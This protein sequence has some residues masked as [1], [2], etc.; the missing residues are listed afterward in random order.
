MKVGCVKYQVKSTDNLD[1]LSKRLGMNPIDLKEYHNQNC[2]KM[3]RIWFPSLNGVAYLLIPINYKTSEQKLLE[4]HQHLPTQNIKQPLHLNHYG[5]THTIAT[6]GDDELEITYNLNFEPPKER[7]ADYD[8]VVSRDS[9]ENKGKR[10]DSKMGQLALAC[11][12]AIEPFRFSL[13][14]NGTMEAVANHHDMVKKFD[15]EVPTI[16]EYFTGDAADKY[17]DDF[18]MGISKLSHLEQQLKETLLF[19]L[20]F[21]NKEWMFKVG[22]WKTAFCLIPHSF[23]VTI[24]CETNVNYDLEN[25]VVTTVKGRVIEEVSLYELLKGRRFE[26]EFEPLDGTVELL[27]I[28][29]K[30][31]K[32]LLKIHF[33]SILK[34]EETV[35]QK[36]TLTIKQNSL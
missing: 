36:Q 27:I 10:I 6:V 19:Q 31:T 17:L 11:M 7:N 2:P 14:P 28:T 8:L 16:K 23:P 20:L 24:L 9:F 25:T 22:Q 29:D 33:L 26:N 18:K 35:Y 1:S 15:E 3:D 5:V 32:K 30:Q 12:Q 21:F 4:N 34:N 13:N